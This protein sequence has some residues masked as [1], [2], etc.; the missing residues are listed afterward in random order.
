MTTQE[1]IESTNVL[2]RQMDRSNLETSIAS[3]KRMMQK[4]EEELKVLDLA[5]AIRS[6]EIILKEQL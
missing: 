5:I 1:L 3:L 6:L 2:L 4:E